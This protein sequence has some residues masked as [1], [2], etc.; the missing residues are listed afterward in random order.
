MKI[1]HIATV[2]WI[3][4]EELQKKLNEGFDFKCNECHKS[5]GN[6]VKTL[7][8]GIFCEDCFDKIMEDI[9]TQ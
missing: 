8:E 4:P 9:T 1:Y 3:T 2:E 6:N 5:I 7:A